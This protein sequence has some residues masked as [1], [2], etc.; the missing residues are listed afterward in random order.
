MPR[1]AE[2]ILTE[3]GLSGAFQV[4]ICPI[5]LAID[6]RA[7]QIFLGFTRS[8]VEA[9][10]AQV[11]DHLPRVLGEEEFLIPARDQFHPGGIA[12][13]VAIVDRLLGPGGCPWDIAQT[14][15]SLKKYLLEEAYELIEAIES[16]DESN[17]KEE[18]GDVLLQPIMHAQIRRRD[19]TWGIE[20]VADEITNKLIRRHPH[21]FGDTEAKTADQVL[22]NWDAI[23]KAEK[24][25]PQSILSG[26]PQSMPALMLATEISKRAARSGFEW[27][28]IDGVWA[29]FQ[30]EEAE[31]RT[32]LDSES[33]DRQLA[34]L[35]DLLFTVVNIAR[36][37]KLDPEEA[38]RT[39]VA[40]FRHRFEQMEALSDKPLG[41]L[42]PSEWD[43]LWNRVKAS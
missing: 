7:H 35:G 34:E 36:W 26:V 4:H 42:S 33:H 37:A 29:K 15:D 22:Q 5:I 27:P 31:L 39:M 11:Y 43:T 2:S 24:S 6:Q 32:A 19:G 41:E 13:L 16:G 21:V 18:L 12:G 30:E 17:L 3:H 23:K 25:T 40:R 8:E 28:D 38:L 14:H 9:Y 1:T 20:Q 10:A